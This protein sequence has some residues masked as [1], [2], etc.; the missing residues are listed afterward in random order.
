MNKEELKQ[1]FYKKSNLA[2]PSM[3][4]NWFDRNI[5]TPQE[6][7]ISQLEAELK[8]QYDS[9]DAFIKLNDKLKSELSSLKAEL[10]K[11]REKHRWIPVTE[12]L[13]NKDEYVLV[14]STQMGIH[15]DKFTGRRIN[16]QPEFYGNRREYDM[17][18]TH[19]QTL[20]SPPNHNTKSLNNE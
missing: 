3:I 4:W 1:K 6:S 20:P 10:D 12:L 7:R 19:W 5:I 17:G 11:E 16:G 8:D 18:V 15:E 9:I 2:V 14:Y 13:P